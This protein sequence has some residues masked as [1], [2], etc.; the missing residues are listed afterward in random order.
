MEDSA[1]E[2]KGLGTTIICLID[3]LGIGSVP[4]SQYVGKNRINTLQQVAYE[5]DQ[6]TT[7][8]LAELGIGNLI[9]LPNYQKLEE[10]T[11]F[12]LKYRQSSIIHNPIAF[13]AEMFGTERVTDTVKKS[14]Q[15]ENIFEE[16]TNETNFNIKLKS[17]VLEDLQKKINQSFI[18]PSERNLTEIINVH[19]QKH[20]NSQ[21]PFLYMTPNHAI[22]IVADKAVCKESRL[23]KITEDVYDF[24]S[25]FSLPCIT[26]FLYSRKNDTYSIDKHRIFTP[27]IQQRTILNILY[28]EKV[29]LYAIG[30]IGS[31]FPEIF[32]QEILY[33]CSLANTFEM[34]V[35]IKNQDTHTKGYQKKIIFLHLKNLFFYEKHN[36][37]YAQYYKNY[38]EEIDDFL[39]IIYRLMHN[40]DMLIIT[41]SLSCNPT[42][43]NTYYSEEYIP[44][45]IYS[46]LFIP[47]RM[48]N[49]GVYNTTN[50]LGKTIAEMYT[51]Q[52]NIYTTES[53]WS[54]ISIQT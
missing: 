51:P 42:L 31:M 53:F 54:R 41:S 11:G 18:I 16:T 44:M 46:K 6:I 21:L 14:F 32:F 13:Y 34:L 2:G 49:L 10:T 28:Q 19:E 17:K 4:E 20:I 48:G 8:N 47:Y 50:N 30:E 43:Q 25:P 24:F 37:D 38:L 52:A 39:P 22:N 3:G 35:H 40:E 29:K 23:L 33:P 26:M 36:L 5:C 7:P 15:P 12:Y 9:T 1:Q 45:L 27:E